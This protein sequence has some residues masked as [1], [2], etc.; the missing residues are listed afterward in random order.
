[1]TGPDGEAPFRIVFDGDRWLQY[2][3]SDVG[4]EELGSQGPVDYD[5][6]GRWVACPGCVAVEWSLSAGELTLR[7]PD[8]EEVPDDTRFV[9]EGT[10]VYEPAGPPQRPRRL[11]AQ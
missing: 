7:F 1:M 10:Y 8:G 2:G 9:I 5:A 11:P 3:T 6:E 4:I